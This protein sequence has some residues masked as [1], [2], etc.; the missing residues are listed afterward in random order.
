MITEIFSFDLYEEFIKDFSGN[1][2]FA[3]PHFEFDYSNLY[4]SLN[5]ANCNS[6][7]Q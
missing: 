4:D 5:K 1:S 6:K 2:M 3:D 7:L